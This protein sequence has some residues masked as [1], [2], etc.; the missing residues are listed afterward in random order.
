M[1]VSVA[2]AKLYFSSFSAARRE[3]MFPLST[4]PL[5]RDDDIERIL[6]ILPLALERKQ[7]RAQQPA[8]LPNLAKFH[9]I[10]DPALDRRA[11]SERV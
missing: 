2:E 7:R 1:I 8:D 5:L 4:S 9:P 6:R 11:K 3:T 10:S